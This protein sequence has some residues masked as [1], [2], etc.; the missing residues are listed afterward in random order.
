M[1]TIALAANEL[2]E[3]FRK[4][5]F[6]Q[7]KNFID[8]PN[9]RFL[10]EHVLLENMNPDS[11]ANYCV[12]PRNQLNHEKL[13]AISKR[14]LDFGLEV[15]FIG[16]P[17]TPSAFSTLLWAADLLSSQPVRVVPGDAVV[18]WEVPK[19]QAE[20]TDSQP[21]LISST[22]SD[23]RWAFI[24]VDKTNQLANFE[25]KNPISNKI[26]TGEFGFPSGMD[27]L[28][29]ASSVFMSNQSSHPHIGQL[30]WFTCGTSVRVIEAK[31]FTPLASPGD[32]RDFSPFA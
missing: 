28:G 17:K 27:L 32:V 8:L 7:P 14:M 2:S 19:D 5:K 29:W 31:R 30:L 10:L 20:L 15:E 16:A 24:E 22:S 23:D 21:Y 25:P 9:G 1:V 6:V 18:S 3:S 12:V 11:D 26:A 13:K 4:A